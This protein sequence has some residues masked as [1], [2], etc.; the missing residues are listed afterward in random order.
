MAAGQGRVQEDARDEESDSAGG[1]VQLIVTEAPADIVGWRGTRWARRGGASGLHS[2]E[3]FTKPSASPTL[4]LFVS[5]LFVSVLTP[6]PSEAQYL[7]PDGTYAER[8]PC[9]LCPDGSYVGG[10]G[11][12]QLAPDGSYV[13]AARGAPQLAPDG[14]YLPGGG[15]PV[16][17]PNGS[18]VVGRSCVLTPD[19]RY[20]G[21]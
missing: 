7:C 14:T 18:Y 17:C 2:V 16:L 10:G 3:V 9:T 11:Q 5:L 21:R 1:L 4:L 20:I 12:C 19:G 6:T 8:G 13:P 15:Q